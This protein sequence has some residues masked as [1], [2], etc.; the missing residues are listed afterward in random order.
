MDTTSKTIRFPPE[1]LRLIKLY[2]DR[3]REHTGEPLEFSVAVRLL[4]WEA[5]GVV[6]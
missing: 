6:K 3:H 1:L 2:R 4:L 5:L